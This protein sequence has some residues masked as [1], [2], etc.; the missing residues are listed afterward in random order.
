[1]AL[2][3]LFYTALAI[4]VAGNLYRIV[5]IARMPAHLRWELYPI[6]H[7]SREK[8]AYGGSYFEDSNWWTSSP[9]HGRG[10]EL[11]YM[12]KEILLLKSVRENNPAL[13][14]C[15]WLFHLGMYAW[16][17]SA[18]L[19]VCV[20]AALIPELDLAA[21]LF[22]GASLAFGAAMLAGS[23][24]AVGLVLLRSTSPRLRP[25]TSRAVVLNLAI[26][27]GT[28]CTGLAMLFRNPGS[29]E[30][31]IDWF[32][33]PVLYGRVPQLPAL[34]SVHIALLSLFLLYFPFSHMTHAYMKFF[35]YHSVRWDDAPSTLNARAGASIA[36]SLQQP[37]TWAA[38]HIAGDGAVTWAEVLSGGAPADKH[39]D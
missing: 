7:G 28:L 16:M 10:G 35:T 27:S 30:D 18:F 21:I 29:L 24:G 15:S 20:I 33:G 32:A 17:L 25:F 9:K 36:N 2:L 34:A 37:V 14:L 39:D 13:W 11:L 23:L 22:M 4:F 5:R 8:Q 26:I 6:P 31:L 1:M 12:A 3:M 19:T 38:P